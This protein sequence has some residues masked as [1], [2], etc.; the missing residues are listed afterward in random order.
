MKKII[1]YVC[2]LLFIVLPCDVFADEYSEGFNRLFPNNELH[3]KAVES[4]S[5]YDMGFFVNS[6]FQKN[7]DYHNVSGKLLNQ[8][9]NEFD[10]YINPFPSDCRTIRNEDN[11]YNFK[12]FFSSESHTEEHII[13][14]FYE[15]EYD[16]R[17]YSILKGVSERIVNSGSN[18][19]NTFQEL[20]QYA[21]KIEDLGLISFY[22]K[23]NQV[24]SSELGSYGDK[25][26]YSILNYTYFSNDLV[27]LLYPNFS[28]T[29]WGG[30]GW[31]GFLYCVARGWMV[32]YYEDTAYAAVSAVTG[33]S[34]PTFA[35]KNILYIPDDTPDTPEDYINAA[36]SRIDDYLG[37]S[38][39]QI[40]AFK[41]ISEIHSDTREYCEQH[42]VNEYDCIENNIIDD[43][44]GGMSNKLDMVYKFNLGGTEFYMLIEK[45]SSKMKE[46]I[47]NEQ[48]NQKTNLEEILDYY[49]SIIKNNSLTIYSNVKVTSENFTS[50]V[51][52][53][54]KYFYNTKKSGSFVSLST[55]CSYSNRTCDISVRFS[56]TDLN[57]DFYG[58]TIFV[59]DDVSI[60]IDDNVSEYFSMVNNNNLIINY[61]EEFFLSDD[62]RES[63]AASYLYK[64]SS[65]DIYYSYDSN[66]DIIYREDKQN[67]LNIHVYSIKINDVV[68]D[69]TETLFSDEF[70]RLTSG[71]L[72]IKSDI[73]IDYGILNEYIGTL[74]LYNPYFRVVTSNIVNNKALI[75]MV[76]DQN[77]QNNEMHII[78]LEKDTNII[79]DKFESVGLGEYVDI[80]ADDPVDKESY[81]NY[82]FDS[83]FIHE[84][85][86]NG[87]ENYNRVYSEDY[88][89]EY[90][91]IENSEV[92]DIQFHRVIP[93]FVGYS[94]ITSDVY[95]DII[96][97][98]I[99]IYNNTDYSLYEYVA[100]TYGGSIYS[101]NSEE[102]KCDIGLFDYS[103]YKFEIHKVDIIYNFDMTD[104][105]KNAFNIKN[106]GTIDII[107]DEDISIYENGLYSY[108]LLNNLSKSY[109]CDNNSCRLYLENIS[110][111]YRESHIVNYNKVIQ[112]PSEKYMSVINTNIDLYLG[113]NESI[114]DEL[115]G[116]ALNTYVF[117]KD[118]IDYSYKEVVFNGCNNNRTK[119]S[120]AL[121]TDTIEIHNVNI[122]YKNGISPK[123][124]ELFIDKTIEFDSI[125]KN[126]ES[127]LMNISEDY[128]RWNNLKNNNNINLSIKI[129]DATSAL[130]KYGMEEHIIPIKFKE[131]DIDIKNTVDSIISNLLKDREYLYSLVFDDLDYVNYINYNNNY[132][133][134]LFNSISDFADIKFI[135]DDLLD[136]LN[137]QHITLSSRQT[138]FGGCDI[139][140][141]GIE[142]G[143]IFYYDGVA[144]GVLPSKV[145]IE[146]RKI[147]Y[148]PENTKNSVEA[149][150][151]A[152]QNRI[153]DYLGADSGTTISFS[154]KISNNDERKLTEKL[155]KGVLDGNVYNLSNGVNKT[156]IFIIKNDTKVRNN[157]FMAKDITNNITVS[158]DN[159]NYP[160]DT[161]VESELLDNSN[162]IN[163]INKI[164]LEYSKI[165]DISLYSPSIGLITNTNNKEFEV[166][167]PIDVTKYKSDKL[168]AYY[169][170]ANGEIERHPITIEGHFGLFRTTHL[171]KY[172]IGDYIEEKISLLESF[173]TKGYKVTNSFMHGFKLEDLLS[174]IKQNIGVDFTSSSSIVTTGTEFK[175][176]DE[177]ITAVIYGDLN[178][179]GKINSADLLKM[180]QHLLGTSVLSG[181]YKEAA[182]IATGT[183][184][185]SADLLRIRQHLLGTKSIEQ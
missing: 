99:I 103:T 146:E 138:G 119:C 93:R 28:Y 94:S 21:Y 124:K 53:N 135:Y 172:L 127:F 137:N 108:P 130:V 58:N 174:N 75:E 173:I 31:N 10:K 110:G 177:T 3:I 102:T 43:Y 13:K 115:D 176:N 25:F 104:D 61:P 162:Y 50:I 129:I 45:N 27:R 101:C 2:L 36:K 154:R 164:G 179:D 73:D 113:D 56:Y 116:N 70:K 168:C 86:G 91:K 170:R 132:T 169:I 117:M 105:F 29:F 185:N 19:V 88:V 180:R 34:Y 24:D 63:Y 171:S 30:E 175:Y 18:S 155:G 136:N 69:Y 7:Y 163:I 145:Y 62:D 32:L 84:R 159:A 48:E 49:D 60:T 17:I 76:Y 67:G 26:T 131:I 97:D 47:I 65:Q 23:Y 4:E 143:L 126:D 33:N 100:E 11:S 112:E 39:I 6:Y 134:S 142:L 14:V 121:F 158:S 122:N 54:F 156:E 37:N 161:K 89:F 123:F 68:F 98:N 81:L 46:P 20:N 9:L 140:F 92:V 111:N 1:F 51:S 66:E 78:T 38:D 22:N 5:C 85:Q 152:A 57:G 181:A 41:K 184:I 150:L 182:S 77:E 35:L 74:G 118:N 59:Y 178:G 44:F 16:Q 55:S 157:A 42:S 109:A 72:R 79:I 114:L 148:I 107:M 144:Y 165:Y 106:D 82:F 160:N 87:Y 128:L 141:C 12:V 96:G 80:K 166:K 149:Y 71:V 8:S 133:R 90:V 64:F 52:N 125:Y 40:E 153:D 151:S 183:T 147:I 15:T 167:L 139:T 120:F 95:S 83:Y